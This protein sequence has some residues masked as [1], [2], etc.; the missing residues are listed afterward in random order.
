MK[1]EIS[2]IERDKQTYGAM[3]TFFNSVTIQQLQYIMQ[4]YE[5]I[6]K[7]TVLVEFGPLIRATNG[8]NI[9]LPEL[10]LSLIDEIETVVHVLPPDNTV[11]ILNSENS[12]ARYPERHCL[13][14]TKRKLL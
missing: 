13:G 10:K 14:I 8:E 3:T 7:I 1:S 4:L 11:D 5:Q 6:R 9:P 2:K 12:S